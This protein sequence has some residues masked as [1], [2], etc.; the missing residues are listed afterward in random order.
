MAEIC[1]FSGNCLGGMR[2]SW[3]HVVV[4]MADRKERT[5]KTKATNTKRN[6]ERPTTAWLTERMRNG[7]R[8]I[9]VLGWKRLTAIYAAGAPGSAVRKAINAKARRCGY[10]PRTI[11]ALNA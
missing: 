5:M 1:M 2:K 10:T 7:R 4:N 11:L 6:D 9:E 3:P 8:R